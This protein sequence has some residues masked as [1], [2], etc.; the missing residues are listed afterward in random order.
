MLIHEH[1]PE[2]TEASE[3]PQEFIDAEVK[4]KIMK[5]PGEDSFRTEVKGKLPDILYAIANSMA[6]LAERA[7]IPD[8]L[9]VEAFVGGMGGKVTWEEN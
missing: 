9:L 3:V 5:D 2:A 6:E 7:G 8:H 4:F 1:I